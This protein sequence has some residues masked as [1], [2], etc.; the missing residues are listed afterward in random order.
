MKFMKIYKLLWVRVGII[1][2]RITEDALWL[3]SNRIDWTLVNDRDGI[4][5]GTWLDT[6]IP[7]ISGSF[8]VLRAGIDSACPLTAGQQGVH[9]SVHAILHE[10]GG[11]AGSGPTQW[12]WRDAVQ[13]K[14]HLLLDSHMH[15][16]THTHTHTHT[17][18]HTHTHMHTHTHTHTHTHSTKVRLTSV[19]ALAPL[20]VFLRIFI[21]SRYSCSSL[22]SF[23][24]WCLTYWTCGNMVCV[25]Q[26]VVSSLQVISK[27]S[28]VA[29]DSTVEEKYLIA[30]SEQPIAAYHRWKCPLC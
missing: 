7:N 3:Y 9:S 10:E 21:S 13:G 12:L 14:G 2:V 27:S 18:A 8:G 29:E 22:S 1:E 28:E 25:C 4:M 20:C 19:I 23:Q 6:L 26:C 17:H 30:T 5:W 11:D 24:T 15:T 16:L